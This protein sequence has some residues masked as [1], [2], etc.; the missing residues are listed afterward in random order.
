MKSKPLTVTNDEGSL[1]E[2]ETYDGMP[3]KCPMNEPYSLPVCA[4]Y[5]FS[6]PHTLNYFRTIY[7]LKMA[8]N[9]WLVKYPSIPTA[10]NRFGIICCNTLWPMGTLQNQQSL[11]DYLMALN[12]T[13]H[14]DDLLDTWTCTTCKV[15]SSTFVNF[16]YSRNVS[17]A[18]FYE[19]VLETSSVYL[20][21]TG[22]PLNNFVGDKT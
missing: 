15:W 20:K 4:S 19:L 10:L 3:N 21:V 17:L 18:F 7:H 5:Y 14:Q 11:L 16:Q 13:H 2:K 8:L 1:K 12:T 22:Y 6:M 9:E